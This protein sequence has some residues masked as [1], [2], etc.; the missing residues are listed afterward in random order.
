[1]K[2]KVLQWLSIAAITAIVSSCGEKNAEK[3][4]ATSQD[5]T[6][7]QQIIGDDGFV[8]QTEQFADLRILKY[9]LPGWDSLSSKQKELVYYLTQAGLAGRD[10]IWDQNYRHNLHIRKS[11]ETICQKYSGDKTTENW[12]NHRSGWII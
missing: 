7:I 9:K 2:F 3:P 8:W 10:I 12:K 11:L 1:M 4:A 6:M 5:T